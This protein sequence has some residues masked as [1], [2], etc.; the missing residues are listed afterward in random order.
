VKTL[1]KATGTPASL[2]LDLAQAEASPGTGRGQR[3]I[4]VGCGAPR[5]RLVEAGAGNPSS[6]RTAYSSERRRSSTRS[7]T[8]PRWGAMVGAGLG[9][10]RR[11]F[12]FRS[13][14]VAW[15]K[16]IQQVAFQGP[17]WTTNVP[18]G[19]SIEDRGVLRGGSGIFQKANLA[20]RGLDNEQRVGSG[21]R[22]LLQGLS[23][24]EKRASYPADTGQ[25]SAYRGA[26]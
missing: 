1:I 18:G 24:A 10:S 4:I 23:P 17:S 11:R 7:S 16:N 26:A 25:R 22:G 21:W 8:T 14:Y 5:V 15:R 19:T 13:A 12:G 6:A 2:Y 9:P 20:V 3:R